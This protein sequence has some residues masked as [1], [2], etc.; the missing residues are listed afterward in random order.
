MME[1]NKKIDLK[2]GVSFVSLMLLLYFVFSNLELRLEFLV[3]SVLLIPVTFSVSYYVYLKMLERLTRELF[4]FKNINNKTENTK[5]LERYI[6]IAKFHV[7]TLH[8]FLVICITVAT[9]LF[10]LYG[11]YLKAEIGTSNLIIPL[12]ISLIFL[13]TGLIT[14][15][16]II[17]IKWFVNFNK[18][19]DIIISKETNTEGFDHGDINK[20]KEPGEQKMIDK[21]KLLNYA[22][23]WMRVVIFY[24]IVVIITIFV[25]TFTFS[26]FSILHTNAE[27]AR[28]MLS[29][30]VQSEAAIVAIVISLS[31]VAIQLASSSY[32]IRMI[33]LLKKYPDFWV[34]LVI[35]VTAIIYGL[36]VLI[37]I[38]ADSDGTSN[39]ENYIY[40]AYFFGV[41]AFL[42]LIPYMW[43]TFNLL[44]P[45]TMIDIL[46]EEVTKENILSAL[47]N[48]K[49]EGYIFRSY[50]NMEKDPI[51]PIIDIVHSSL[52]NYDSD[53]ARD[54]LLAIGKYTSNIFEKDDFKDDEDEE[55]TSHII[56]HLDNVV[57]HAK[58]EENDYIIIEI[59]LALFKNGLITANKKRENA[60]L[61][62]INELTTILEV[63][64]TNQFKGLPVLAASFR[65]IEAGAAK[66]G[67]INV[68]KRLDVP[69][70][71]LLNIAKEKE[72]KFSI[73]HAEKAIEDIKINL[74]KFDE[75]SVLVK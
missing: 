69:L 6:D 73:N 55:I 17:N 18:L 30:L 26:Y 5:V 9:I 57:R 43:T 12:A 51:L 37:L 66:N 14:A 62:V 48:N 7:P 11:L 16:L 56:L 42:F 53:T 44:K 65:C 32:S 54:G 10:S 38:K 67:L 60:T 47:K 58:K 36:G 2:L 29:T 27:S 71:K 59:I 23:P 8:S 15:I 3:L 52:K 74:A 45:S 35:Y 34:L 75:K 31:L 49:Y 33:D 70:N 46:A 22:P 1:E 63:V 4:Y 24:C 64:D 13:V 72:D 50:V 19:M 25:L 20:I 41:I 40:G 28:Y 39:I 68:L 21:K 61:L